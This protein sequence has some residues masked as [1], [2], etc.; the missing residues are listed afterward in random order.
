MRKKLLNYII[1]KTK[2]QI[3]S[4][5]IIVPT[6]EECYLL[7]DTNHICTTKGNINAVYPITNKTVL[8]DSFVFSKE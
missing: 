4:S 7:Y 3:I 8:F 6:L 2:N 5:T 1:K